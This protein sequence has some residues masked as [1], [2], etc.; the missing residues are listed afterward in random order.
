MSNV[1]GTQ[2]TAYEKLSQRTVT[3]HTTCEEVLNILQQV[4]DLLENDL[5]VDDQIQTA[6]AKLNRVV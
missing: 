6:I 2:Q 3:L 1:T 4:E 5:S